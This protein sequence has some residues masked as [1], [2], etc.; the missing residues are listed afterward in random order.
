M[1]RSTKKGFTIVE[2]VIVIAIIAILAAVLIPTFA[3]LIQKAN[4]SKD[5]QLVKNLNTALAANGKE[6]KTMTE[7]LA[8]AAEF[9]Y[10]VGKINASATGNEILWDSENDIFCYLK[11]D[12][13]EY[14]PE[15]SL[16]N[17]K[18]ADY[19]LWK[20]YNA[21]EKVPEQQKYSI[22]WNRTDDFTATLT[23]G[24]DAG[25]CTA[26]TALK[27]ERTGEDVTP[28]EVVIRTSS[29]ETDLTV[30]AANDT[31]MHYGA[32]GKVSVL[33]VDKTHS[34]HE[35]GSVHTLEATSGHIVLESGSLVYDLQKAAEAATDLSFVSNGT[36]VKKADGIEGVTVSETYDIYNLEQLCAF[37]D[38]VNAGMT[39]DALVIEIKADID[40]SSVS[41]MP[42]GTMQHP[43]HGTIKGN[44]HTLSGL[45]NGTMTDV[46]DFTTAST[47]KSFGSAYGLIAWAGNGSVSVSDLTMADVNIDMQYGDKVGA[48][49]GF[50]A[51]KD[52][53]DTEHATNEACQD[54]LVENITVT[55]KIN[56]KQDVGGV[57]GKLY[58]SGKVTIKNCT[59]KADLTA[60][61]I[62]D[63]NDNNK[64]ATGRASGIASFISNPT[65][66]EIT[67][68]KNEGKVTAYMYVSGIA[69]FAFDPKIPEH[70]TITNC[71]N[72]GDIV[73]KTAKKDSEMR[74]GY[75]LSLGG[76]EFNVSA[77]GS[78]YNFSGNTNTG[79]MLD[80][81]GNELTTE[82]NKVFLIRILYSQDAEANN[83][84]ATKK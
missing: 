25:K 3:S 42:I 48:V 21:G 33:A 60:N 17:G 83:T 78:S 51:S 40:M 64:E 23:V 5:T 84:N 30:D 18:P 65:D 61:F 29:G 6:H 8:A 15:T 47:T 71:A 62:N 73:R 74:A 4:E 54:V 68:C 34:Y 82:T 22:Y 63:S 58:N 28:Q 13:V 27:Y 72:S 49:L 41:W 9:G 11:G 55:G 50:A 16:K 44:N 36:V 1:K 10:D 80:A 32:A 19:K 75:I 39:F 14:I 53:F 7:A 2:L 31:V 76:K 59:N 70:I 56:A 69:S 77:A 79:K 43:F 67:G 12:K 37:R 57:C 24:F 35:F 66:V 20:V 52:K 81:N 46:G 26:I 38:H 45:N